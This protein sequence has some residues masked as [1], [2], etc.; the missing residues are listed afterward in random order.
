MV[1]GAVLVDRIGAAPEDEAVL[2]ELEAAAVKFVETQTGRYFGPQ[3]SVTAV[4]R[5]NGSAR[6]W[7]PETPA[8]AVASVVEREY[9][10]ATGTTILNTSEDGFVQRTIGTETVLVR[11][12]AGGVWR[13]GYEY[14]VT[15]T[16][17]YVAGSEPAD[18]YEAVIGL[19]NAWHAV[20]EMGGGVVRSA[21]EGR[22]SRTLAI[23]DSVSFTEAVPGLRETLLSWRRNR[24]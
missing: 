5:G 23:N 7:L 1:E 15:L 24:T 19:V 20:R 21:T 18:I 2:V 4:L 22:V 14:E 3:K 16:V 10:G 13:F 11:K 12:G 9:A 17:G 8:S 6:L